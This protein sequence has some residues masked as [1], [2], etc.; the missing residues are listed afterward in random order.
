M[1][2]THGKLRKVLSLVA[3]GLGLLGIAPG[4]VMTPAG[5]TTSGFPPSRHHHAQRVIP[6]DPSQG[7]H[8]TCWSPWQDGDM[9]ARAWDFECDPQS[10]LP[11]SSLP[12]AAPPSGPGDGAGIEVLPTPRGAPLEVLPSPGAV[13]RGAAA[14]AVPRRVRAVHAHGQRDA[15]RGTAVAASFETS[16]ASVPLPEA[17]EQLFTS[18]KACGTSDSAAQPRP[19]ATAEPRAPKKDQQEMPAGGSG[20]D[21]DSDTDTAT[22]WS[23]FTHQPLRR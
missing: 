1:I 6:C 15:E 19:P 21:E 14:G 8:A 13:H 3:M 16:A 18:S 23:I 17:L 10:V 20:G 12:S 5:P 4:C 2:S 7:F 9:A 11:D 22:A